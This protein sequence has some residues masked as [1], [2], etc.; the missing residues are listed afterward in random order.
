MET[1]NT[2]SV[3]VDL[4]NTNNIETLP[5]EAEITGWCEAAIQHASQSRAFKNTLSVLI[6]V[7]SDEESAD[8]NQTYRQKKGSTN[9][10]SFPNEVP[11]FMHGISELA[12]QNSHLGDLV[13]CS[14]LVKEESIAQ[15]KTMQAHWAHLIV[16]GVLH[17]QGF[18]HINDAEAVQME[19]LEIKIMEQLGFENPYLNIH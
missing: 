2:L 17:L 15:G 18:D 14:S 10:L 9:V 13:I 11:D 5:S 12:E 19:S 7:V 1:L 4:Q 8:L 16:H 6:R 3:V